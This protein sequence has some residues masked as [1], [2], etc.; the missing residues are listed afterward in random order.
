MDKLND[1]NRCARKNLAVNWLLASG[2]ESVL[3]GDESVFAM[4]ESVFAI[5]E[6]VLAIVAG[7][8]SVFFFHFA[9]SLGITVLWMKSWTL[10]IVTVAKCFTP[11]VTI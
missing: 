4:D 5:D 6:S 9:V 7:V 10:S 11:Y 8:I 1:S 2:D 3:A